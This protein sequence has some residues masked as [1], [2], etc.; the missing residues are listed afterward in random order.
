[1]NASDNLAKVKKVADEVCQ[2]FK[3]PFNRLAMDCRESAI[4]VPRQVVFYIARELSDIRFNELGKIFHRDRTTVLYGHRSVKDRITVDR[5][6]CLLVE[7]LMHV[8]RQRLATGMIAPAEN[9]WAFAT[10]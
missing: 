9:N 5:E 3:V 4:T 7:Q 10:R 2:R 6:F 1:V 8:C